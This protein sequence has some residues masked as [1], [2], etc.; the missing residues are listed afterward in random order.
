[1]DISKV[2]LPKK[3]SLEILAQCRQRLVSLLKDGKDRK[4]A[5]DEVVEWL[6][7][8]NNI[9]SPYAYDVVLKLYINPTEIEWRKEYGDGVVDAYVATKNFLKEHGD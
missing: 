5:N 1:M 7:N 2:Y 3:E 6:K 4:T 9:L 8:Q